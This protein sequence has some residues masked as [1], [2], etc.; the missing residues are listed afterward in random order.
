MFLQLGKEKDS[1]RKT[2]DM[3]ERK[4]KKQTEWESSSLI[5]SMVVWLIGWF[6]RNAANVKKKTSV[7]TTLFFFFQLVFVCL[8]ECAFVSVQFYVC[9]CMLDDEWSTLHDADKYTFG[10]SV[11]IGLDKAVSHCLCINMASLSWLRCGLN[12]LGNESALS[13]SLISKS[14]D[15]EIWFLLSLELTWNVEWLELDLGLKWFWS[16][17]GSKLDE[18]RLN[19][20]FKF[21]DLT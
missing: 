14:W 6:V 2:G 15:S 4:N 1:E 10:S 11:H 20:I 12:I 16:W 19:C 8:S 7:K 18:I 13:F 17:M 3:V 5:W 21:L 9:V